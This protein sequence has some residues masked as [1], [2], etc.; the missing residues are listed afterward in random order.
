MGR[1]E[2]NQTNKT[3]L[4]HSLRL[5]RLLDGVDKCQSHTGLARVS[6]SITHFKLYNNDLHMTQMSSLGASVGCF[7]CGGS[8]DDDDVA[9]L[10]GCKHAQ[11]IVCIA[12]GYCDVH[13]FCIHPEKS[14]EVSLRRGH[15]VI[16]CLVN[17]AIHRQ[18][19]DRPDITNYVHCTTG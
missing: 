2:L 7:Y 8:A 11:C 19:N 18:A 5:R 3:K 16:L 14:E 15:S 17:I 9:V 6:D 4:T 12:K 13:R 1:K 10:D